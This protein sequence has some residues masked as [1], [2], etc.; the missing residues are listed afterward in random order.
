MQAQ[1]PPQPVAPTL[2]EPGVPVI[3]GVNWLGIRTLYV[4]EVRRFFKVQMQT[5]WAPAITTLMFLAIFTLA[6]GSAK[7]EVLGFPYATFL[8][9]GL[10]IM[11][12]TQNAFQN[13]M[14]SL[15][16]AKVQGT[17]VD[18]LMPPLSHGELLA[19]YVAG[20]VTRGWA[21][22]LAVWAAMLLWPGVQVSVANPLQVLLFGTL[23]C[24]LLGLLGVLTGI[25]ADKFDHGAAVTNFV[26]QPL[27]LL[28]GT[29]YAIDRLPPAMQAVSRANPFFYMIDGFRAG[30]IGVAEAPVWLGALIVGGLCA[31]LWALAYALLKSGWKLRA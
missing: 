25:W 19:C 26:V 12:M 24:L 30:F 8:A 29:F 6:L 31:L 14:S 15:I 5:I 1:I 16:I 7:G 17:I 10:I 4:K 3:D 28:S 27:T 2:P 9:P 18:V 11:G 13:S 22:G 20:A 23:G 21:V